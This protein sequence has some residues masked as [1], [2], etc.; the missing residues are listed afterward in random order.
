M[1]T[2]ADESLVGEQVTEIEPLGQPS[3]GRLVRTRFARSTSGSLTLRRHRD[4]GT[5]PAQAAPQC[6]AGLRAAEPLA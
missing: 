2:L 3:C 6:E 5:L 1:P 4:L